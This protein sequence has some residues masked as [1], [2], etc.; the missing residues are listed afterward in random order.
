M[1][2]CRKIL[3]AMNSLIRSIF[4]FLNMFLNV[5]KQYKLISFPINS[6]KNWKFED[7]ISVTFSEIEKCKI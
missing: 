3:E 1:Q 2:L 5:S 6:K 4:N 7:K